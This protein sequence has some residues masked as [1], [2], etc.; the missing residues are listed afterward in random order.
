MITP[1]DWDWEG[2]LLNNPDVALISCSQKLKC[3]GYFVYNDVFSHLGNYDIWNY[4]RKIIDSV[5]QSTHRS[6]DLY[7]TYQKI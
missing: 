5:Q 6:I 1:P 2:Y 3:V 4:F 7:V